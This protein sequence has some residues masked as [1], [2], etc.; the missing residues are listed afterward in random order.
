MN[1]I[2]CT[3]CKLN[4][5]YPMMDECREVEGDRWFIVTRCSSCGS[6]GEAVVNQITADKFD[7][8]LD[9]ERGRMLAI[10]AKAER[11]LMLDFSQRFTT[12]LYADALL[13]ED[14]R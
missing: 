10:L 8:A 6:I 1:L 3:P 14:F 13:P 2:R 7:R 11:A 5:R 9:D 4:S 12:A